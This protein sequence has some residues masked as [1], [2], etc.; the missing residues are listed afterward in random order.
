M[1]TNHTVN[2]F[3][4]GEILDSAQKLLVQILILLVLENVVTIPFR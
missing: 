1:L 4:A 3:T 2:V